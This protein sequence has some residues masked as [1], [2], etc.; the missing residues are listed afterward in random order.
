MSAKL[1]APVGR[2]AAHSR[3]AYFVIQRVLH[4]RQESYERTL[5]GDFVETGK[6]A[7]PVKLDGR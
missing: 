4:V 2:G 5:S 7:V 6:S 3:A 1:D